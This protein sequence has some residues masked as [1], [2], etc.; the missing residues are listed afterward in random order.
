[1]LVTFKRT[2][3]R[4][5]AVIVAP[6]GSE[7]QV[8]DPAPGYD[9]H[10]PHDLVHYIVEAELR[11]KSGVFGRASKGGGTF[12]P[13]GTAA[14]SARERSRM[15]RKQRRREQSLRAADDASS[16]DM[17]TSERF[18]AICDVA[19]RRR[20]GQRPDPL[21]AAPAEPSTAADA[22]R[23]ERVMARLDQLA[24]VWHAM[25]VGGALTFLWPE[26]EPQ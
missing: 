26:T 9:D 6:E 13:S 23:V 8:I 10:V 5:Y 24:P 19:W 3:V 16:Q 15:Q 18:A 21:R 25:P 4:R 17:L 1:M 11:L 7:A 14:Q 22:Q 2:G 12:L 20:H